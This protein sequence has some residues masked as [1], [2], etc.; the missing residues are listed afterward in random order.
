MGFVAALQTGMLIDFGFDTEKHWKFVPLE[1]TVLAY[2]SILGSLPVLGAVLGSAQALFLRSYSVRAAHWILSTTFGFGL[3][4]AVEWPLLAANLWSNF[5]GPVEPII[6]LVGGGS[7]AGILQ[8]LVLRR[9]RIHAPRWLALWIGGLALSLVPTAL[10][11]MSLEG[12]DVSVSWPTE[13]FLSGFMVGGIGALVSGRALFANLS[14]R[15]ERS[16]RPASTHAGT[17]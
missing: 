3:V 14:E 12:L 4:V 10:I 8:Y 11:F 9:Q 15:P 13:A 16:N 6:I 1:Q 2:L 17:A 5:P 7:L